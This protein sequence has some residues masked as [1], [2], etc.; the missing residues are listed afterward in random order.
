MALTISQRAAEI[1]PS[2]TLAID[3]KAK[4]MK[5]SGIDVISFGAGEPDFDTPVHIRNAAKEALDNGLT[6]YTPVNGTLVLRKA[7]CNK[8]KRDNA[9]TYTPDEIIVSNGA[10]HSLFNILQCIINPG[11]E[12]IIP[13]PCWVSYPEL[14]KMAGGVP[15][16]VPTFEQDRFIPSKMALSKAVSPKTKA[17]II[18]S[19]SNPCGT[20]WPKEALQAVADLAVANQFYVISDEIYEKLLY[21]GQSHVSIASLNEQIKNQ[22]FIV[23]GVS[24]DYAMTG[25]RIGYTAGPKNVIKAMTCYQSQATSNP[26]SIA[27]YASLIALEGD[28]S[29]VAK[30]V[31]A[32]KNRRDEMV[33][34]INATGNISCLCPDGAFYVMLNIQSLL[35]K[36]Y[37]DVHIKNS[38]VFAELL[39]DQAKVAVVP[40]IAFEAEGYCRLSYAIKQ[41]QIDEGLTRIEAFIKQLSYKNENELETS[42]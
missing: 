36:Y 11:D 15:I 10:K 29:C 37:K 13:T 17:I 39:L 26:N 23:N 16:F 33:K 32:F 34:R 25:W 38:M 8:F 18:T 6:R 2:L 1:A 9:L 22:T 21:T 3:A 40:G 41:E 12:V 19:P 7:I 31:L 24:K 4:E 27:Q 30:M 14:V 20:V 28:Q 5:A 42:A 35:G